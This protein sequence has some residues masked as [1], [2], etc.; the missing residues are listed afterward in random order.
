MTNTIDLVIREGFRVLFLVAFP[1][2]IA[3]TVAGTLVSALQSATSIVDPA[4][5]YAVRLLA[6]GAALYFF[7]PTASSEIATLMELVLK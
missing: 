4:A 3:A 2:V 7:L 6:V 1:V 5:A